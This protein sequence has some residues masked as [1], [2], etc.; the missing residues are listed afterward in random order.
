MFADP[1]FKFQVDTGDIIVS[2]NNFALWHFSCVRWPRG[3]YVADTKFMSG[4]QKCFWLEAK[5]L[6]VSEQQN[7]FLQH[8]FHARLNW[9]TFALATMFPSLARLWWCFFSLH[10][11]ITS[12]VFS[13]DS[14]VTRV[15]NVSWTFP[16]WRWLGKWLYKYVSLEWLHCLTLKRNQLVFFFS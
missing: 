15:Q 2:R 12:K 7:L 1:V 16:V 8:M 5:T 10:W 6:F 11:E 4:K 9:E 3:T 13:R 14:G